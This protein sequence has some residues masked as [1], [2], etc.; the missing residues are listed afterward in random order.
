MNVERAAVLLASGLHPSQVATIIGCS[1]GRISQLLKEPSFQLLLS[2]KE[3]ELSTKEQDIE[4]IALSNKYNATEHLL[5][6]QI[7]QV[8]PGAELRDLTNALRVVAERQERMKARTLGTKAPATSQVNMVVSVSLPSH[9]LPKPV[10]ERNSQNEVLAV[11]D[12]T[13]APLPAKAVTALFEKMKKEENN[14]S[15]P[16]N[17]NPEEGNLQPLQ[18]QQQQSF[19]AFAAASL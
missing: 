6:S 16:S 9:A 17:S 3:A 12:Q 1:P 14:E 13:L 10:V 4:E 15:S 18:T 11:G 5:L 8:A 7:M 19:L 2:S